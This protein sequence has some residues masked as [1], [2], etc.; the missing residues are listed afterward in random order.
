MGRIR[1][2]YIRGKAQGEQLGDKVNAGRLRWFRRVEADDL[3]R[4]PVKGAAERER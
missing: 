3:L 4:R 1:K 2:E